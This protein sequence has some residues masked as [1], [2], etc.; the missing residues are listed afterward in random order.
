MKIINNEFGKGGLLRFMSVIFATL[1]EMMA[2]ISGS[3][4]TERK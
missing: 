4:Q 2:G 3:A 1:P